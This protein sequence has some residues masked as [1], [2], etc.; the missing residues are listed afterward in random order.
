M[1]SCKVEIENISPFFSTF[2]SVHTFAVEKKKTI[3]ISLDSDVRLRARS[4]IIRSMGS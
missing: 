3:K 4:A 1:G 2:M